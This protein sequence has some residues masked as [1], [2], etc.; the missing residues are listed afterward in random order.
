MSLFFD[1]DNENDNNADNNAEIFNTHY[2][3]QL[4]MW[5][6]NL[7]NFFISTTI[8]IWKYMHDCHIGPIKNANKI[9]LLDKNMDLTRY[10][11]YAKKIKESQI[12]LPDWFILS[13]GTKQQKLIPSYDPDLDFLPISLID[14]YSA[15]NKTLMLYHVSNSMQRNGM[16]VTDIITRNILKSFANPVS[17]TYIRRYST[18]PEEIFFIKDHFMA[19]YQHLLYALLEP[20]L[21]RMFLI[22]SHQI[23]MI[24]KILKEMKT[25]LVDELMLLNLKRGKIVHEILFDEKYLNMNRIFEKLW[26]KLELICLMKQGGFLVHTYYIRKYIGNIKTYCPVYYIPETTI[27]YDVFNDGTFII[28]PRKAYFEFINIY[29]DKKVISIRKLEI[30][31]IYNI[32][33][34]TRSSDLYRYITGEIIRVIGY[35]NGSPK[36]EVL[37]RESDLLKIDNKLIVPTV[38]EKILLSNLNMADYCYRYHNDILKIYIEIS[39]SDYIIKGQKVCDIKDKIKTIKLVEYM[40]DKLKL[41]TEIR[42]VLPDTFEAL[43]KNRYS[44]EVDP[45]LIQIPRLIVDSRDLDLIKEKI[46]YQYT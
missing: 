28:D 25:E 29:D 3:M 31:G 18:S 22:S 20:N 11:D 19:Y 32:V 30:G 17:L 21:C 44:D 15:R 27:G 42:I 6:T 24:I 36:I 33:I 45:G 1:N 23:Y 2:Q 26:P 7:I 43:Y 5:E 4:N 12:R 14:S 16:H 40:K 8:Q 34:S 38:I 10:Y 39:E 37:G 13:N 41:D 46:V 35:H 9:D